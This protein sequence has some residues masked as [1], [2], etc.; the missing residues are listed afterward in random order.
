MPS[1][2]MGSTMRTNSVM[3]VAKKKTLETVTPGFNKE[4]DYP[5]SPTSISSVSEKGI[6]NNRVVMPSP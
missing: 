1:T 5:R 4:Y 3:Q 2:S 6:K